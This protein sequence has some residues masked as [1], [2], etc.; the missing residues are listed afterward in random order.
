VVTGSSLFEDSTFP[1]DEA[2]YYA[3]SA[4]DNPNSSKPSGP[5]KYEDWITWVRASDSEFDNLTLFGDDYIK[6]GDIVQGALG[7]CWWLSSVTALAEIPGRV[8]D[9]FYN[10]EKSAVGAYAVKLW[11]LNVPITI[12]VDDR[13]PMRDIGNG[14]HNPMFA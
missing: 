8:E 11:A 14:V 2:L 13:L 1:T 7:N 3:D 4:D 12:M 5:V 10:K 6:P 9:V